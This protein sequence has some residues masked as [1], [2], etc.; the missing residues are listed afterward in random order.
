MMIN[1]ALLVACFPT[2]LTLVFACWTNT[3]DEWGRLTYIPQMNS[4]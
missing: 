4:R 3:A 1:V 2:D